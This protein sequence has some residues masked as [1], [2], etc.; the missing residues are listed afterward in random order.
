MADDDNSKKKSPFL[1]ALSHPRQTVALINRN[2]LRIFMDNVHYSGFR[3][4]I[5]TTKFVIANM[6]DEARRMNDYPKYISEIEDVIDH[7]EIPYCE[8]PLVSIIIPVY[9]QYNFTISCIKSIINNTGD[10]DY[11]I[12]LA[13]DC[14]SDE[15]QA[16]TE[17]VS[18]L[19]VNRNQKNL[20]FLLNCNAASKK[21][22]GDYLL[23]LNNDV[24]VGENWLK[25]MVDLIESDETIGL[26]G[27]K[28]VY[29][30]GLLQEAGGIIWADG[31]CRNYGKGMNPNEPE[32]N[33]VKDVD[34]ISGASILV[35]RNLFETIG[36]F[37][38]RY[39]PAYCE[40]SDLALSVKQLGYSVKYQPLSVITHFE[41]MTHKKG[42]YATLN[43]HQIVNTEKFKD[44]WGEYLQSHC[45][46][47]GV[48]IFHARDCSADKKTI[49]VVMKHAPS[50]DLDATMHPFHNYLT[51]LCKM[52][53]NVKLATTD[54]QYDPVFVTPLQQAGI[55]LICGANYIDKWKLFIKS[56]RGNID[57]TVIIGYD[58][59]TL[60]LE[61]VEKYSRSKIHYLMDANVVLEYEREYDVTHDT[62]ALFQLG[63]IKRKERELFKKIDHGIVMSDYDSKYL[64]QY[65]NNVRTSVLYPANTGEVHTVKNQS[66]ET[67]NIIF[68]G[69]MTDRHVYDSI[70]WFLLEIMPLIRSRIPSI[71]MHIVGAVIPNTLVAYDV[72][73]TI[74]HGHISNEE[75]ESLYSKSL[76]F[77]NPVRIGTGT[78]AMV[79]DAMARGIPVVTTGIGLEYMGPLADYYPSFNDPA[80][81]ANE[82]VKICKNETYSD[83]L[84]NLELEYVRNTLSEEG[85]K[86]NIRKIFN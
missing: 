67:N 56:N 77:V 31:T 76:V 55:E 66:V 51:L 40:D 2:N 50:R 20:G 18:N 86:M 37:D 29:P 64:A 19:K 8:K 57:H 75:I 61:F 14:S 11:E 82:I 10:V 78:T 68:V 46:P 22:R 72:G 32:Y 85:L 71:R 34:F 23:F 9:N 30:D 39:V 52:G 15:T 4:A 58:C 38:E 17:I 5:S 13:D 35:R 36:G 60:I 3:A 80:D 44:K 7:L 12:I 59:A 69:N 83:K 53:Y 48:D 41:G 33:Y 73:D 74:I 27:S 45:F 26:V 54:V 65:A 70:A 25:P 84:S 63:L 1:H 49:L 21:A 6:A 28:F 81:F 62:H 79:L 24:V 42:V 47:P 43:K 16:I